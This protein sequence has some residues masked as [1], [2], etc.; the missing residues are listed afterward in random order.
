MSSEKRTFTLIE[1]L[2]VISIIGLLIAILLPALQKSR[3]AARTTLCLTHEKQIGLVLLMYCNDFDG[4]L[5][6]V[7]TG[8]GGG[9]NWWSTKLF[10]KHRTLGNR[11]VILGCP[12]TDVKLWQNNTFTKGVCYVW[13]Q[14]VREENWSRGPQRRLDSFAWPSEIMSITDLNLE[15][16]PGYIAGLAS[17]PATPHLLHTGRASYRHDGSNL[18]FLDGHAQRRAQGWNEDAR[19]WTD[20]VNWVVAPS[21]M[22]D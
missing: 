16:S 8:I 13:N 6:D 14:Y 21:T 10:L 18:L 17:T 3:K 4:Q 1:L 22:P 9:K 19:L 5:P 12:S 11:A 15:R 7:D 20:K 2:V